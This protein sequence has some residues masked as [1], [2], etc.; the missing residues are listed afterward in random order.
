MIWLC[1]EYQ[2]KKNAVIERTKKKERER[3]TKRMKRRNRE[4]EKRFFRAITFG[5]HS[6][7]AKAFLISARARAGDEETQTTNKPSRKVNGKI[8]TITN[9]AKHYK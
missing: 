8:N 1:T 5:Q 6:F 9:K 3:E 4:I 2:R 7:K